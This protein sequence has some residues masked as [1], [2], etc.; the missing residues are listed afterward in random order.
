MWLEMGEP[1]RL[2]VRWEQGPVH[3]LRA[4]APLLDW[5]HLVLQ[6]PVL[7]CLPVTGC[8]TLTRSQGSSLTAPRGNSEALGT[9]H[10]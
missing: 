4:P 6:P 3:T 9:P 8:R 10:L 1:L 2:V 5:G 7:A